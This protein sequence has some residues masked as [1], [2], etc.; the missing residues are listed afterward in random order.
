V[1]L[2]LPYVLLFNAAWGLG[3]ARGHLDALDSS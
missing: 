3:E 2:A 1:L